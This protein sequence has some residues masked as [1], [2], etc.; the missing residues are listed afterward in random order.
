MLMDNDGEEIPVHLAITAILE[1][2]GAT[3][4]LVMLRDRRSN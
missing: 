2:H 3:G 1:G 4:A